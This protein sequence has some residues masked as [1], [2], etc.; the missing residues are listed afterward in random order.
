MKEIDILRLLLV[1]KS[2]NSSSFNA[3]LLKIISMVLFDSEE[4]KLSVDDIRMQ[5]LDKYDLEFTNE[6]IEQAISQKESG[7]EETFE[8]KTVYRQG[9]SFQE[10]KRYFSL[11]DQTVNKYRENEKNNRLDIIINKYLEKKEGISTD[12]F[13]E[14]LL[15][16]LYNTFNTNKETL[17]L[18]LKGNSL[19]IS[20]S[21]HCDF[22]EEQKSILNDFLNWDNVE[23]NELVFGAAS[24]CVEYCMLTVKKDFSSYRDIFRGKSFYLDSNVIFR[25]A[26]I[27]NEERKIVTSAFIDKCLEEGITVKY[28]NFTYE[29]IKETV[30]NHVET[31]KKA[32]NGK[33]MVSV[34]NWKRFTNPYTNLDFIKLYDEWA[35]NSKNDY[36]DFRSFEKYIMNIIQNILRP[37]KKVD[38]ITYETKDQ[39]FS[40]YCESLEQ[41]KTQRKAKC[42]KTSLKIDINNYLYIFN[43]REK[44]K[45]STFVDIADYL[46]STDA[47]LCEWG[48]K[49]LPSSIPI[50]V[51]P[52][53][54]HS[55]ILKFKGRTENDYQAFTLFLNLRYRLKDDDFDKRRPKI[56]E[57]V[58]NLDEPVNL[59]NLILDDITEKLSEEYKDVSNEVEIIERSK[60]SVIEK[61]VQRGLEKRKEEILVTTKQKTEY[62]TLMKLAEKRAEKKLR[63][64]KRLSKIFGI[65]EMG[66]GV[67]FCIILLLVVCKK[68][69]SFIP[70]VLN[71]NFFGSSI[72]GWF[73]IIGLVISAIGFFIVQPFKKNFLHSKDFD[74]IVEE[75]YI[76]L[77][78]SIK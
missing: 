13:K 12:E 72:M 44:S 16:F 55:L 27:N 28:T 69:L 33:R 8:K 2:G 30:H 29:E 9:R 42:N 26:G 23:K 53:V 35:K 36:N 11:L 32:T 62:E 71:V 34:K 48:K 78:K 54:W 66:C 74:S 14:L 50:A 40:S 5:I 31:I 60:K 76:K 3:N 25:L 43:L 39:S 77:S 19:N 10:S 24:Y 68:G 47:N 17:L 6:E 67:M 64:Y 59:K 4:K 1:T 22:T 75:E 73:E 49:I 51:L 7:I 46:I 70:N 61:E 38:F 56:L 65:I 15:K 21:Q 52:S 18:F 41:Y 45:G 58:Q 57:I 63:L 20:Q 37:F